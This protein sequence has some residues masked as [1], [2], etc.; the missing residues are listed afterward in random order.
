MLFLQITKV[1]KILIIDNYDSFTYN[2][3]QIIEESTL[4]DFT[5]KQIDKINTDEVDKYD[6]IM[7]SPGPGLPSENILMYEIID[8]YKKSKSILGVCLGHQAIA[9]YFGGTLYNL[10]KVYHGIKQRIEII[11]KD[12]YL[13]NNI[14]N[15]FYVG[16]Y[17]SWTVL[18]DNFPDCLK[19][20]AIS[21]DNIIMALSHKIFDIKGIQF[22]PESIM[23]DYGKQLINNWI[24]K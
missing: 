4:C 15:E 20:T 5:I 1:M 21:S 16:L 11:D 9:E 22:H 13:F 14:P 17:H 2:L 6:K 3:A 18:P 12:D 24:K 23:T 7:F 10:K 8:R 19:L